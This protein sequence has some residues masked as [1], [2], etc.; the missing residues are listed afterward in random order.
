MERYTMLLMG[1]LTIS[2]VIFNSYVT[3]YQRVVS[4]VSSGAFMIFLWWVSFEN[5]TFSCYILSYIYSYV[6][7]SQGLEIMF[8][9]FF[10]VSF[11]FIPVIPVGSTAALQMAVDMV[12]HCKR[13]VSS[14]IHLTQ[15]WRSTAFLSWST[16]ILRSS[17]RSSQEVWKVYG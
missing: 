14:D 1:K 8:F 3:N 17:R 5:Q 13:P 7:L 11:H 2:M 12:V 10:H 16:W 9:L 4:L 6:H 15:H